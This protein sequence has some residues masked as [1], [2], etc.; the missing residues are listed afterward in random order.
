MSKYR[1]TTEG[2]TYMVETEDGPAAPAEPDYLKGQ[3]G[4]V[5]N[6]R[7]LDANP[8]GNITARDE[9]GKVHDIKIDSMRP[10][11]MVPALIEANIRSK[12]SAP[13]ILDRIKQVPITNP[14]IGGGGQT[15]GTLGEGLSEVPSAIG[16]WLTG[17]GNLVKGQVQQAI[18]Q[19]NPILGLIDAARQAKE[20]P[21]AI[22]QGVEPIARDVGAFV[23]PGSIQQA[24]PEQRA[25]GQQFAGATVA[26]LAEGAAAER[27]PGVL[28]KAKASIVE[29]RLGPIS[30]QIEQKMGLSGKEGRA[31]ASTISRDLAKDQ[32]LVQA[33]AGPK[34][35]AAVY[36]KFTRAQSGLDIAEA[37][38]PEGV[39]VPKAPIISELKSAINKL[40]IPGQ[41]ITET[42]PSGEPLTVSERLSGQTQKM[43][44]TMK[45]PMISG[46]S[47][48]VSAL[49][50]SL[51][52]IEKLPDEIPFED[53]RKYRQQLDSAIKTSG[54]FKETATS[55][56]R[57]TAE[58]KRAVANNI[59]AKLADAAPVLKPANAE[60]SLAH[61]AMEATGLNF[62]DGRRISGSG[63]KVGDVPPHRLITAV[64]TGAALGG[65]GY[66]AYKILKIL[67]ELAGG[68]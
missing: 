58:A 65:G 22:R 18:S 44:T 14:I 37:Q 50:G 4:Y 5:L 55:A 62:E 54:G 19:S 20:T 33:P 49:K 9:T 32:A 47:D 28:Q 15:L 27:L 46:H 8:I 59:R 10:L 7:K 41:T 6:P 16:N 60:Y 42:V 40:E 1:V 52:E 2:G 29:H 35:D 57:A 61:K 45:T 53:L 66:G 31:V 23:A 26:G 64:K 25:Q 38:V 48:A 30:D 3:K 68:K 24:T 51:N 17:A 43:V 34:F 13:G 11:E 56:E 21:G 39:T 12:R 36:N 67:D 63:V